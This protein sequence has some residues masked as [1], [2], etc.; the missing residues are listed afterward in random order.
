MPEARVG[1]RG[2]ATDSLCDPGLLASPLWPFIC[3]SARAEVAACGQRP[4]GR[5]HNVLRGHG[6]LSHV[7][8]LTEL[9]A[10]VKQGEANPSLMTWNG[11]QAILNFKK[12][13]SDDLVKWGNKSSEVSSFRERTEPSG[14]CAEPATALPL[15]TGCCHPHRHPHRLCR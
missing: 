2:S 13:M 4:P 11:V 8:H 5:S 6:Q 7:R 3:P 1:T 15:R 9:P 12:E 14:P 10:A